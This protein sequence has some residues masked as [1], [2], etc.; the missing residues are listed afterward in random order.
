MTHDQVPI[1]LCDKNGNTIDDK[2]AIKIYDAVGKEG[3]K[4]RFCTLNLY[5]CMELRDDLANLPRVHVV[6]NASMFQTADDWHNQDERKEWDPRCLVSFQENAWVDAKTHIHAMD[7]ILCPINEHLKEVDMKGL[8]IEDNLSSHKT[9]A[10][11][12]FWDNELTSFDQPEFVPP[13]MTEIMQ[14]IDW[15]VGILYKRAVYREMRKETMKRLH[16][17]RQETGSANGITI[18]EMTPRE[19]R[20]LIT[21][22]LGD[23]HEKLI[24]SSYYWRAFIATGIWMPIWYLIKNED[25]VPVGPCNVPEDAHVSLQHIMKYN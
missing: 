14:A 20:I 10:V 7:E 18:K 24:A 5:G 12:D 4:K 8:V 11:F 22:A 25:G 21:R 19:K 6:F 23:C 9:K 3:D 2:G 1:E 15:H 16:A 17:A 13:K